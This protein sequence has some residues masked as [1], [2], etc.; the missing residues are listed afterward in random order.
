LGRKATKLAT[1]RPFN[2]I[3]GDQEW[4]SKQLDKLLAQ[5]PLLSKLGEQPESGGP[6]PKTLGGAKTGQGGTLASFLSSK[7]ATTNQVAKF[8]AT[9]GWL[10]LKGKQRMGTSDITKALKDNHQSRLGNPADCLNQN[11]R[12]GFCEKDGGEF[13]V[14]SEGLTHLGISN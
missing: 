9:A 1:V 6:T 12:K 11:V 2:P 14:T 4:V 10:Y 8:L 3:K 5:A 13:F 7:N